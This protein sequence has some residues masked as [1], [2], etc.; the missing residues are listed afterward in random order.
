MITL[1]IIAIL[2]YTA[3]PYA[4]RKLYGVVRASAN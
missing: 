1:I 3:T 2:V 4:D